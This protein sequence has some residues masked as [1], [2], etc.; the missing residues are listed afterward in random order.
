MTTKNQIRDLLLVIST[1]YPKDIIITDTEIFFYKVNIW[2]EV[3]KFY[4][5][6]LLKN[7]TMMAL[8]YSDSCP[9]VG[10]IVTYVMKILYKK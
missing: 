4:D 8:D 2:Y 5:Y 10:D 6:E 7:A 1:E 9:K 3:L